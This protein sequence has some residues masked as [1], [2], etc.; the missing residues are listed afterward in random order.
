[1]D[2]QPL[3]ALGERVL[4]LT[5]AI[6]YSRVRLLDRV[7][8][9][10]G[11]AARRCTLAANVVLPPRLE[12]RSNSDGVITGAGTRLSIASSTVQRPSPESST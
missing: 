3:E 9:R 1:M 2:R 6:G 7:A 5:V 10:T 8:R 4:L 12:K 11:C